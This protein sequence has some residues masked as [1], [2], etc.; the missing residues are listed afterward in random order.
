MYRGSRK[1][2]LDWVERPTFLMELRALAAPAIR[3]LDSKNRTVADSSPSAALRRKGGFAMKHLALIIVALLVVGGTAFGAGNSEA[4]ELD[5]LGVGWA[6]NKTTVTVLI[7]AARGV[8]QAAV[9]DV[10]AAVN[11]WNGVGG[12]PALSI[13]T[14]KTADI[15]IHMKVGG[16]SVLGQ[17]LPKTVTPFSCALKSASIQLSGRAFGQNFSSAGTRNVA[18]HELG[19]A[20]GLGHSDDS[21]DLMYASAESAE[22]FGNT[23]VPI[24]ACDI[25]GLQEIYPLP[26]NCAIPAS[27]TCR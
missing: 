7:N 18:R 4:S 20:L 8:S 26:N 9:D 6:T 17:T 3:L 16:G 22:I 23:D 12:A 13:V 2:V 1:H 24:S 19:H 14:G 25:D 11:D 21:N 5:L 27:V 10:A 15:V